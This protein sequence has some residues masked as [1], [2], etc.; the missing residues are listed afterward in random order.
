LIALGILPRLE[1]PLI[2]QDKSFKNANPKYVKKYS[3]YE[4]PVGDLWYPY[5][6]EGPPVPPMSLPPIG[7]DTGR[8]NNN[9]FNGVLSTVPSVVPEAFMDTIMINGAVYPY[10]NVQQRR[11]RFRILNASQARFFNL[12]VY[13][14][15]GSPDGVT[16]VPKGVDNNGNP[17]LVPTNKP[18]P[19][20]LQIGN[21]C[22]FLPLPVLL[23][24]PPKPIGYESSKLP[25]NG[26]VNRYTLLLGSAE[27][28]DVIIDFSGVPAGTKLLL[29]NDAP[30]PFPAGD[31]R[32]DYYAGDYDL[33]QIG[34]A[35][36]TQPG[37]GPNTRT[38]MQFRV[39]ATPTADPFDLASTL[40]QLN[41]K[42]PTAPYA[43]SSVGMPA[44]PPAG[45]R[46]RNLTLNEDFDDLGR[47]IQ[48][49]GTDVKLNGKYGR[50]LSDAPTET[51]KAGSLEIWRIFNYTGDTH[52]VHFHLINARLLSRQA[53]DPTK[54]PAASSLIPGTQKGPDLNELG[55]KETIRFNPGEA[56]TMLVQFSLPSTPFPVPLSTRTNVAGYEYVWH[57][58]ILEHEE[59]DMMRPLI[60]VP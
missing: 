38:L 18:G 7:S 37:Y 12:Q 32:N 2:I 36:P 21:E 55:F 22:G 5:L 47:L 13:V 23:N 60:V 41:A 19:A 11:Y 30:A 16:L 39:V 15:D 28:A 57:C 35:P 45:I 6:Y 20:M 25:T 43:G 59:H 10:L 50:A 34:G 51:P 42:L 52:P 40:T 3:A 46:I 56:T 31:I 4:K 8:W 53:F 17:L 44:V 29:Y 14:D 27:R 33:T 48:L 49:L 26:N 9:L 54:P 58:H 24:D 1:I